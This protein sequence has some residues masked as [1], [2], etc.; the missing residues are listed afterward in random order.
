MKPKSN[1]N[2]DTAALAVLSG[3]EEVARLEEEIRRKASELFDMRH[4]M[5]TAQRRVAEANN[6]LAGFK[7][8]PRPAELEEARTALEAARSEALGAE[9]DVKIAELDLA[10]LKRQQAAMKIKVGPSHV[11]NH[12]REIASAEDFRSTLELRRDEMLAIL[13]TPPAPNPVAELL[14]EREDIQ[15]DIALGNPREPDLTALDARILAATEVAA[16]RR[17][18][19]RE[20]ATTA[21]E[22]LAGIERLL[23]GINNE[24]DRL[25]SAYPA[26]LGGF[27]V[28]E[29]REAAVQYENAARQAAAQL[30]RVQALENLR[31]RHA[32][33]THSGL[34]M[35]YV[36]EARFPLPMQDEGYLNHAALIGPSGGHLDAATQAEIDRLNKLGVTLP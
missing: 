7:T 24:L 27:L 32:P 5:D 33:M 22:A 17:A 19:E 9:A 21:R 10:E 26:L 13:A 15:A 18:Q 11:V 31:H 2:H 36:A 14:R 16:P 25:N 34:R 28:S 12:R 6:D 4:A 23:T 3:L 35:G 30:L 1:P 29:L 20:R 8:R